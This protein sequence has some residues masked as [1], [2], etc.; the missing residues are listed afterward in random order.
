MTKVEKAAKQS[1]ILAMVAAQKIS[2]EEAGVLLSGLSRPS[3]RVPGELHCKVTRKGCVGVYGLQ[4]MPVVLYAEQWE[5]LLKGAPKDH[6]VLAFI[7]EWEGKEYHG[8]SAL[9]KGGT[10]VDYVQ[11][12]QR[13]VAMAA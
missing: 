7:K 5:R 1:E 11:T 9:A 10:K 12:I 2:A 4:T 6:F 13:K 8:N 3:G